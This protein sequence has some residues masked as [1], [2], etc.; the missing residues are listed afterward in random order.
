MSDDESIGV[1]EHLPTG[2]IGLDALTNGGLIK[3]KVNIIYGPENTCKSTI[4]LGMI[5][6]QQSVDPDFT[7]AYCDNEKVFDRSYATSFGIDPDRLIVSPAFRNAEQAYDFCIEFADGPNLLVVD[8]IQALASKGE[9]EDS[10]GKARST[11]ANSMALI[12]RLLSQFLRMYTSEASGKATL[13]L[14]SQVRLDLGAFI[15]TAKKTGGKAID[16][17]NVLNLRLASPTIT[18]NW[19]WTVTKQTA[20][21]KSFP[22]KVK[23]D[24]A[25]MQGRH[26]GNEI[27]M[28]FYKGRFD[29]TL[30]TLAIAKDLGLWDGKTISFRTEIEITNAG[31]MKANDI[32]VEKMNVRAAG[33]R[34]MFENRKYNTEAL[35]Y[36]ESELPRAYNRIANEDMNY[37]HESER[38]SSDEE[39]NVTTEGKTES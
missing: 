2:N 11:E 34:D 4:V 32:L 24:K 8:T 1:I 35:E 5:A 36:L 7:A 13:V 21:P 27:M 33:I 17:Y 14:L 38:T 15:P 19:P 26:D 12:P 25:K 10:K 20:P 30:N 39:R 31:S 6:Y 28:Y 18:S 9:L 22:I 37:E 23:I 16:H 3:N 29:K